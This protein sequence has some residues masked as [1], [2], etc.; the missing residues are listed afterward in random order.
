MCDAWTAFAA[1]GDPNTPR[2]GLPM[3]PAYDPRTR[4]TLLFADHSR[5]A[6]DPDR[7]ERA[8]WGPVMERIT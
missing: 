7:A 8:V 4:E 6:A 2:S 3:W 5:V 1:T